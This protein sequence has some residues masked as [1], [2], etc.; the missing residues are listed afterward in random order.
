[1]SSGKIT[2]SFTFDG[3][4]EV[5]VGELLGEDIGD[6]DADNEGNDD[7][8][9]DIGDIEGL[10]L[11]S[12]CEDDEAIASLTFFNSS[13]SCKFI[14]LINCAFLLF[15]ISASSASSNIGSYLQ[16][17]EPFIFRQVPVITLLSPIDADV[18]SSN[19]LCKNTLVLEV[20]AVDTL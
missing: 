11:S 17:N 18:M 6:D 2:S 20:T 3:V 8:T 4:A 13:L 5:T 16:L 7:E 19:F 1:M 12:T 10:V 14:L 15:D 9:E